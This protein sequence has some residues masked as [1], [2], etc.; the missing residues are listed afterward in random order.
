[1]WEPK[2]NDWDKI[3]PEA[4]KFILEQSKLRFEEI[5]SESE[6]ITERSIKLLTVLVGFLSGLIGLS[7]KTP[8]ESN[9]IWTLG[10]CYFVDIGSLV[11]LMKGKEIV[12]RGS[13]PKEIFIDN[14]DRNDYSK[15]DQLSLLYYNEVCRYQQRIEMNES[16]NGVRQAVY[17]V[18]LG[19][20]VVLYV[21]TAAI[22][23]S[24][25]YRP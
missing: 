5:I 24:K 14:L 13:P 7:L 9:L 3:G 8:P 23:I 17:F 10:I 11:W 21:A 15:D 20:S 25:V 2:I 22:I 12:L 1:M 18:A 16:A 19:L 6:T 4:Y